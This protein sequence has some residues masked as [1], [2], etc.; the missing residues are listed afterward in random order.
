[1]GLNCKKCGNLFIPR[2]K[3]HLFCSTKCQQTFTRVGL[4]EHTPKGRTVYNRTLTGAASELIAA[5][6]FMKKGWYVFRAESPNCPCDIIIMRG[7]I[8]LRVEVK[9]GTFYKS[10]GTPSFNKNVDP[11]KFDVLSVVLPDN[12]VVSKKSPDLVTA[13]AKKLLEPSESYEDVL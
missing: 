12:T 6:H 10:T 1:M 3:N 4:N 2:N 9:S 5:A 8:C 13:T 7:K 11:G